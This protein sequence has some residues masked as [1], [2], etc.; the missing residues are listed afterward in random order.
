MIYPSEILSILMFLDGQLQCHCLSP[1]ALI[2]LDELSQE[3]SW[4]LSWAM[5]LCTHSRQ[6][7]LR[8]SSGISFHQLQL[9]HQISTRLPSYHFYYSSSSRGRQSV[10]GVAGQTW[11]LSLHHDGQTLQEMLYFMKNKHVLLHGHPAP[12]VPSCCPDFTPKEKQNGLD[13]SV[14]VKNFFAKSVRKSIHLRD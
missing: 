8:D 3:V 1:W 6:A 13:V 12:S 4:C 11:Y 14:A 9:Y 10:S 5:S 2:S 7:L